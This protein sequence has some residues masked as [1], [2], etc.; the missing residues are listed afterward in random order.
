MGEKNTYAQTF[1]TYYPY[2]IYIFFT[3][4]KGDKNDVGNKSKRK[5]FNFLP[6]YS[7]LASP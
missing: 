1:V 4:T 7:P 5:K 3:K 2:I 6:T